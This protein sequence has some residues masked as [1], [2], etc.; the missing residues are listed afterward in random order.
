MD[1]FVITDNLYFKKWQNFG[2][3]SIA[4]KLTNSLENSD[5]SPVTDSRLPVAFFAAGWCIVAQVMNKMKKSTS[6]AH[7]LITKKNCSITLCKFFLLYMRSYNGASQWCQL[8]YIYIKFEN[9]GIF[10][11]CLVYNFLVGIY[12]KFVIYFVIFLSEVLVEILNQFIWL[13]AKQK[14]KPTVVLKAYKKFSD[15]A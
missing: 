4:K 15:F 6:P 8:V 12:E 1:C 13:I 14:Q 7:C 5:G 3:K 10:S 11:K 2:V 9:F